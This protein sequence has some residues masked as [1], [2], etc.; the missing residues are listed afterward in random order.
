SVNSE[1]LAFYFYCQGNVI[2]VNVDDFKDILND[3]RFNRRI[4]TVLYIHGFTETQSH[5]SIRCNTSTKISGLDPANPMFTSFETWFTTGTLRSSDAL[6]VDIIHTDI[7]FY[8]TIHSKGH[9][10]FFPNGGRRY[11]PGCPITILNKDAT[12]SH[13]RSWIYW[14]ESLRGDSMFIGTKAFN[15]FIFLTGRFRRF[16]SKDFAIMGPECSKFSNGNYYFKT[17][18]MAPFALGIHGS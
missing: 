2:G 5:D 18:K 16:R 17:A 15:Y 8:G 10:N 12:C 1:S 13:R 7:G 9:V 4:P 6:F 3:F 14:A 11:Q